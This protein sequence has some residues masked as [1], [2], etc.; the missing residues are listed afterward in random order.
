MIWSI[1]VVCVCRCVAFSSVRW[2]N[3]FA[4]LPF[5]LVFILFCFTCIDFWGGNC[6]YSLMILR[7]FIP[8][9]QGIAWACDRITIH[10]IVNLKI[11]VLND[12]PRASLRNLFTCH[13]CWQWLISHPLH[14]PSPPQRSPSAPKYVCLQRFLSTLSPVPP[15]AGCLLEPEGRCVN[16]CPR[17]WPLSLLPQFPWLRTGSWFH[18]RHQM[19]WSGTLQCHNNWWRT[20]CVSQSKIF[21]PYFTTPTHWGGEEYVVP[22]KRMII[23]LPNLMYIPIYLFLTTW[24]DLLLMNY[25]KYEIWLNKDIRVCLILLKSW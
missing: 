5:L 2:I 14:L 23:I 13:L 24:L 22:P 8:T 3:S 25:Q 10:I 21:V 1:L 19:C 20:N 11:I 7:F 16:I 4:I 17:R 12:Q 15:N 6:I 18:K 9:R